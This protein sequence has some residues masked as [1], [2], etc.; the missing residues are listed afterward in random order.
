[1]SERHTE[2]RV[3]ELFAA[4]QEGFRAYSAFYDAQAKEMQSRLTN[5]SNDTDDSLLEEIEDAL[6]LAKEN[7]K[8]YES[9]LVRVVKL[10]EQHLRTRRQLKDGRSESVSDLRSSKS[11]SGLFNPSPLIN[12][13]SRLLDQKQKSAASA[14]E[15]DLQEMLGRVQIDI[16]AIIG[17][18]RLGTGDVFEVTIRHGPQKWKARGKTLADKTQKWDHNSV[19]M[20]VLPNHNIE[21]KVIEVKLFRS[22]T[23]SERSFDPCK[24]FITESQVITMNLNAVGTIRLQLIATWIPLL[25]SKTGRSTL[26]Q[27]QSTQL[28]RTTSKVADVSV[29]AKAS[30]LNMSQSFVGVP[31]EREKPRVLM[32]EKKKGRQHLNSGNAH[33][34]SSTNMLDSVY[35]DLSKSIPTIDSLSVLN[36]SSSKQNLNSCVSSP[37]FSSTL[38]PW[39]RSIS[40]NH[41]MNNDDS[42]DSGISGS[43]VDNLAKIDELLQIVEGLRKYVLK[44]R[45]DTEVICFESLL[46]KWEAL[47]KMNRNAIDD[48]RKPKNKRI[49]KRASMYHQPSPSSASDELDDNVILN[50]GDHISENDSGIDS[51]RQHISPYNTHSGFQ[52]FMKHDSPFG[53]YSTTGRNESGPSQ[54]RF[55]QFKER[56]KSLGIMLDAAANHDYEKALLNSDKFW[57]PD[58]ESFASS[59]VR[60]ADGASATGHREID[61]CLKHHLLRATTSVKILGALN[62][63]L[64][65]R[66]Y[67]MLYRLEQDSLCLDQLYNICGALPTLPN[68]SNVLADLNASS[69][70]QEIW[71]SACYP[72]NA[73]LVV[74]AEHV[75]REVK[76]SFKQVIEMRYPDLVDTVVDMVMS[77]ISD[78]GEWCPKSI[79]V[80]QFVSFFRG[81]HL[82][83]FIENVSHEAWIADKLN[84]RNH[85]VIDQLMA[86]LSTV[87]VVPPIETL[88]QMGL[89]LVEND[90]TLREI[91]GR[92]L[93]SASD[94]MVEDLTSCFMCLL[95]HSDEDSRRGA[96]RALVVLEQQK[97]LPQLEF[98]ALKDNCGSVRLEA[99][100]SVSRL[101][102]VS[103]LMCSA[104]EMTKI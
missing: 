42:S 81:M 12:H 56:R 59:S 57:E 37:R 83:G 45:R 7:A 101:S 13:H 60:A 16:K 50:S 19:I 72:V 64:E 71:L 38:K 30:K 66:A 49:T 74:S 99:Q 96:C 5:E 4:L 65:Y 35:N 26:M 28:L 100:N 97:P 86:R 11:V 24:F 104:A 70:L 6:K 102:K 90:S 98:L 41:L 47:L 76:N 39:N 43:M 91:I 69:D 84:T 3:T 58:N 62:G 63:P 95:E 22:R 85:E 61:D 77:M 2:P 23:L 89:I 52:N 87:P 54:R 21:V 78:R 15:R 32:R 14:I 68:L 55:K 44:L 92:Y 80:F 9:H 17:F 33:W 46:L 29:N 25:T 73:V 53:G 88:R 75:R 40:M 48:M 27:S 79:S 18:A 67:E 51:L 93:Q 10:N 8:L 31:D 82:S 94:E 34:R 20:N 103:A 1:M 36:T